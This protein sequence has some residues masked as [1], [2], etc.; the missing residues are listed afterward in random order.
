[1]EY[2][3]IEICSENAMHESKFCEIHSGFEPINFDKA[4]NAW[5]MNKSRMN[6]DGYKYVC[7]VEKRHGGYCKKKIMPKINGVEM[8]YCR[9]HLHKAVANDG[10]KFNI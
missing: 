6:G 8:L 10:K 7:G 3:E 9:G 4:H 1:M 2:C 5:M